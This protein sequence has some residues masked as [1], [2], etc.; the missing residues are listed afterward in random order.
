M[1]NNLDMPIQIQTNQRIF[2]IC[3]II[4]PIFFKLL[5]IIASILRPGYS[6]IQTEISYLGIGSYSII[7]NMN[8]IISGLLSIG[9]AIGLVSSLPIDVK[10]MAKKIIAILLFIFGVGVIFA[11]VSL[12]SV[13]IFTTDYFFYLIHFLA[14]FIAFF[15]IIIAQLLIWWALQSTKSIKWGHYP[16]FSFLS[17]LLSIVMLI[18]FLFTFSSSYQGLTERLFIIVPFVWI[19]VTGLKLYSMIK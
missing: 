4:M 9:F 6:Q 12:I 13:S 18:L 8:F 7:Q 2:I 14:T 5:V 15:T 16:K 1:T 17:G 11:G 10:Q 19:E 3:G